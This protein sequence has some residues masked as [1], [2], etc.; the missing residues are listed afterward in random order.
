MKKLEATISETQI[1]KI[2]TP[3]VSGRRKNFELI[4]LKIA[5]SAIMPI[6]ISNIS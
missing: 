4:K 1:D 5:A 2:I 3:M 6:K